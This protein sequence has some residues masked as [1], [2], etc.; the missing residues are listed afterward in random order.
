MSEADK[1]HFIGTFAVTGF[2]WMNW[3]IFQEH[4][5]TDVGDFFENYAAYTRLFVE[6]AEYF[7]NL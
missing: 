6:Q 2:Y 4:N 1:H 7:Y 3:A 5:G